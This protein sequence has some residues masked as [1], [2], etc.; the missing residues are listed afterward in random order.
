MGHNAALFALV[1]GL[2]IVLITWANV[3]QDALS[4][5]EKAESR[6]VAAEFFG[7]DD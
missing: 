7:D 4:E 1:T 5:E 3:R 6:K 2:I